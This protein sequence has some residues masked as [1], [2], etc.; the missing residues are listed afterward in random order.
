VSG[1]IEAVFV[2]SVFNKSATV[3]VFRLLFVVMPAYFTGSVATCGIGKA[4][5]VAIADF[6]VTFTFVDAFVVNATF[7][8]Y[9][10][11]ADFACTLITSAYANAAV[12]QVTRDCNCEKWD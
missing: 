3:V 11:C 2:V 1:T 7:A 6:A 8:S 12:E 10:D 5:D 9:N 4:A